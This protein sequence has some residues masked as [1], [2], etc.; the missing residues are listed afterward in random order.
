[1]RIELT[2]NNDGN[3][4]RISLNPNNL[5]VSEASKH[6]ACI[7]FNGE[8]WTEVTESYSEV[9]ALIKE[10]EDKERMDKYAC[11]VIASELVFKK[12]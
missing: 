2:H 3:L 12:H 7:S 6:K 9:M 8:D 11:A 1:M 4:L 5:H 10:V